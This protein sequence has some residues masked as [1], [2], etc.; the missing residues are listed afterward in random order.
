[1][2]SRHDSGATLAGHRWRRGGVSERDSS[3]EGRNWQKYGGKTFRQ[4]HVS[5]LLE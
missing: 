3:E 4:A 1:M 2:K 5:G